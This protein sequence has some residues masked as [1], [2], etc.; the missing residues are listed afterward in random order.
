ML[1]PWN[2]FITASEYFANRFSGS[3]YEET[4]QSYFSTYFTITNMLCFLYI[5][6]RQSKSTSSKGTIDVLYPVLLNT[7]IFGIM[8]MTVEFDIGGSDY[9][10]FIL[11]L[12]VITGATTSFFQVAVFAEASQFPPQYVQ[13][14]M[15]GQGIAGV[16]VALSSI[17]SAFAAT[18]ETT[19]GKGGDDDDESSTNRSAFIYFMSALL[20]TVAAFIGRII[21]SQQPFYR[22]QLQQEKP[23][24]SSDN[25]EEGSERQEDN[26]GNDDDDSLHGNTSSKGLNYILQQ[27]YGLIFAVAYVFIVTLMVFPTITSLIKSVVRHPPSVQNHF[28]NTIPSRFYDDDVFIAF[29]FLLFNVGDWIGRFL[30]LW[31]LFRTFNT[32]NLVLLSVLRTLFI[33]LFLIC[34][35]VIST[36]RLMPVLIQSDIL[37]FIIILIFSISN[38]WIGSLTMMAAPQQSFIRTS[39]QKSKIGSIMSFSLVVGLAIG[40]TLSFWVRSLI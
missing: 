40:G 21:L 3:I 1:L 37:Y 18:P 2:V 12:L 19:N 23:L 34:N 32:S 6:W 31:S 4:F 16:A 35:V 39:Q 13:A 20:V 17:L 14:V 10:W 8:S 15:S 5:L 33:P 7:I 29:H 11:M 27:S 9:F 24:F 30:P 38:G 36:E 26:D 25:H 22:Y 28:L